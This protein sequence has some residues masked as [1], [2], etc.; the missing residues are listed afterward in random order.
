MINAFSVVVV[1]KYVLMVADTVTKMEQRIN[2]VH[3]RVEE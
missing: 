2:A 3:E 1:F